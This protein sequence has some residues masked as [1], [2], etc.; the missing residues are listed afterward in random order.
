MTKTA[1]TPDTTRAQR[2][3]FERMNNSRVIE[4]CCPD[5]LLDGNDSVSRPAI[6]VLWAGAKNEAGAADIV[7]HGGF[8]RAVHLVAQAAHMDVDQIGCRNE[9][10]FPDLL[11]KHGSRQ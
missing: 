3:V 11:K 5:I 7:D 6:R 9:F 10:I 4:S 8:A 2:K 1:S